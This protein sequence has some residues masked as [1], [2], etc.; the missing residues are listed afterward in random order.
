MSET[1]QWL[2]QTKSHATVLSEAYRLQLSSRE[3]FN[4]IF[5]VLPAVLSTAAAVFAALPRYTI[6]SLPAGSALAGSAAILLAVHKALKCDEYQA[7]CLR[8][9]QAYQSIAVCAESA[10]LGPEGERDE[11]KKRLTDKL[12]ALTESVK[13]QLPT[14][15]IREAEEISGATLYHH[16][17]E[18]L[19]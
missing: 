13:A 6:F 16:A 10:L 2:G 19:L 9:S 17:S 3:H 14:N 1:S 12:E 15:C 7:E 11:H 8:L 18:P 5:L 4:L